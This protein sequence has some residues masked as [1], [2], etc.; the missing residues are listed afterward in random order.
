MDICINV[1]DDKTTYPGDSVTSMAVKHLVDI[2]GGTT[3]AASLLL[4]AAMHANGST[5]GK[6]MRRIRPGAD[7]VLKKS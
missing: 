3:H 7:F 2:Q 1:A 4:E 5:I 6:W